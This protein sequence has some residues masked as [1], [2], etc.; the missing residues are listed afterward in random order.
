MSVTI[1]SRWEKLTLEQRLKA[2]GNDIT[3]SLDFCLLSG[4]LVSGEFSLTDAIPTACTNGKDV[5]FNPDFIRPMLREQLRYL[6]IHELLHKFLKHHLPT[7]RKVT[8]KYPQLSNMAMD[9]VING[10]I[11]SRP[12]AAVFVKRPTPDAL[13]DK[14]FDDMSW[15][16]VLKELLKDNEEP[17][18][19]GSSEGGEEG[20]DAGDETGD[21]GSDAS[22]G[23]GGFDTHDFDGFDGLSLDEQEEA[24]KK[25][26]DAIHQGRALQKRLMSKRGT[27]G[28]LDVLPE[29]R[30]TDW[31]PVMRDFIT[32]TCQ[33][34]DEATF[35]P[36]NRRFMPLDLLMPSTYS[37]AMDD[38][39][40]AG[41]TSGS[42][43]PLY[44]AMFGEVAQI[45]RTVKPRK[46]HVV[47]WDTEVA[48][49]QTF[50]ENSYDSI[51]DVL[52]PAGGGGTS[53]Q[54]VLDYL[55][56]NKIDPAAIVWLT[57]GYIDNF[58]TRPT[59]PS[60]WGVL[61]NERF[62]PP[63]GKVVH[64]RSVCL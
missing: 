15:L 27:G 63:F 36:P 43:G 22:Q 16:Q 29:D 4:V 20:G 19:N 50:D 25:L 41:D 37:E 53:P 48:S 64:V 26:D 5:R 17:E 44:P 52:K 9:Y 12:S 23:H 40:V 38:L 3:R 28:N 10:F 59:C 62:T 34:D 11:E 61:D 46:V 55:S 47:W 57:D 14:R 42:M 6:V 31:R 1:E 13:V 54:C 35:A 58:K 39:V 2:V 51:K 49:V 45:L 33:G 32:D 8:K 21:A 18:R 56:T 7:Y 60:L 24:I 30:V